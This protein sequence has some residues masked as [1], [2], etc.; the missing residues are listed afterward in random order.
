MNKQLKSMNKLRF[1]YKEKSLDGVFG[2][3]IRKNNLSIQYKAELSSV[4]D[5]QYIAEKCFDG[6]NS[7][8]CHTANGDDKQ[9][10]QVH[11]IDLMFKIEGFS[12]KNRAMKSWDP[13]K[14]AIQGS[15]NGKSFT[16]INNFDEDS[17]EVCGAGYLRSNR[18][19]P[20]KRYNY[21]RIKMNDCPCNT[22]AHKHFN[23]G[24]FELFGTFYLS[25]FDSF[26]RKSFSSFFIMIFYYLIMIS[27]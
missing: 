15:T 22:N 5:S 19:F 27:S 3:G 13:L 24:E 8:F 23:I 16:T 2:N 1:P 17:D 11:F 9:Y 21:F 10:L 4:Y 14:Y 20:R 18:V 25:E 26:I 7:T 6:I 12:I